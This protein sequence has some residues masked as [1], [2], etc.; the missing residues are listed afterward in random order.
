MFTFNRFA[1]LSD[2][3]KSAQVNGKRS[4]TRLSV[5]ETGNRSTVTCNGFCQNIRDTKALLGTVKA[6]EIARVTDSAGDA[7]T[8]VALP[9]TDVARLLQKHETGKAKAKRTT[10][11]TVKALVG[12]RKANRISKALNRVGKALSEVS[13]GANGAN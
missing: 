2:V 13:N 10:K 9:G 8:G 12:G 5:G 6:S 1:F 3:A 11:R 4:N 7:R